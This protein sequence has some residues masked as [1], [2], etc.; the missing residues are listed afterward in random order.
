MV[1]IRD[2]S[3]EREIDQLKS[4]LVSTASHELHTSLTMIQGFS[5]LLLDRDDL[6]P[7]Q[8]HEGL[9]QIHASSQRL[10]RLIDDL[11]SVSRIESGKLALDLSSVDLSPVISEVLQPFESQTSRIFTAQV[12][13][14]LPPALADRDKT[15]QALTNL[16][17]N[18]VK[19]SADGSGITVM[20]GAVRDHAE[21][22]AV[23]EGIGMTLEDS[24]QVFE[25]FT[26]VDNAQVR[27]AGYRAGVAHHEEPG[28]GAKWPVVGDKQPRKWQHLHLLA[29]LGRTARS[30]R[31]KHR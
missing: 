4:S 7:G 31:R 29:A 2:V 25:K 12:D 30:E 13:P 9:R 24:I 15:I 1:V 27:K 5:E 8:T 16:V 6:D 3:R 21:I 26:R 28:R 18:A 20:A 10:G 23:D 11:L 19:Y 22:S 17:S 14:Q